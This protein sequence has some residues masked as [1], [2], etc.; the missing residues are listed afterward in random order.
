VV[1]T[2]GRFDVERGARRILT[3]LAIIVGLVAMPAAAEGLTVELTVL[4]G[5]L[6]ITSASARQF[7]PLSSS[8][9][10][11]RLTST[12]SPVTVTDATG[13]GS[14]WQVMVSAAVWSTGPDGLAVVVPM[15][16][17]SL[18]MD[19]PNVVAEGTSSAAPMV[20]PGPYVF[21]PDGTP[22]VI[23]TAMPGAGMGTYDFSEA[24]LTLRPPI[25]TSAGT[26]GV[27]ISVVVA[28]GP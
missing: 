23:A 26:Y 22:L 11:L 18:V 24:P 27:S 1:V 13:T 25:G 21:D 12:L 8:G 7:R 10:G 16:P 17:G 28:A 3:A 4:P 15:P 20:T 14:G 5:P 19:A 6:G 2:A 9:D